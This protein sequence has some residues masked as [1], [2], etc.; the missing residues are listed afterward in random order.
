ME[1][2]A[3]KRC[4]LD[5]LTPQPPWDKASWLNTEELRDWMTLNR[6]ESCAAESL[7]GVLEQLKEEGK[8]EYDPDTHKFRRKF[9][10]RVPRT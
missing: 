8:I 10:S 3:I 5:A 1:D 9:P 4:I 7:E 6:Q 2:S